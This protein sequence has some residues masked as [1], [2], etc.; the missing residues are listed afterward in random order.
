MQPTA[1]TS[2]HR[3]YF[4]DWVRILAFFV[5]IAYHVGMY[6]VSWGW[7][8]KSPH[9]GA[10]PEPFML[11]SSPWRLGL[12]FFVAG[13]ASH[14][15]LRKM[16][17]GTFVRRRSLRLLLPLLFGM[18]AIVPP[19]P[20]LEVVEKLGYADGFVAFMRLYLA[21]YGG[22]CQDGCLILPTWNHLWF[23]A[24]LWVY[25]LALAACVA[26]LGEVR[27]AALARRIGACLRGWKLIA[28]PALFLA[29]VRILLADHFP[30][31]HALVDD[32][33]NH[34]TYLPLFLLGALVARS[35][36]VWT[37]ME[38][39]RWVALG[40]A[41]AAWATIVAW[42]A[43]PHHEHSAQMMAFWR[44]VMRYVYTLCAWGAIVAACG[45]ARRHLDRDGPARRYLTDAVFP[46]YIAHQ[47][48][49]VVLAHSF[50]PLDLAPGVE[51]L[52][53]M[54]LTATGSFAL[55]EAVR[56]LCW[57]R[58]LFGLAPR[59]SAARPASASRPAPLMR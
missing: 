50:K 19:Q 37:G 38:A 44:P 56:R 26:L 17:P 12:L 32:W 33:F 24:Y 45:F 35:P 28:L 58:P 16:A 59:A 22:F 7:H 1:I 42:Y 14:F 2:N 30:S 5:L 15:L 6:Y 43:A 53:L 55:Y 47:T 51:A 40:I 52:M 21:G 49:I 3:L 39:Q 9:A 11:L 13:V 36:A 27:I 18:L 31:T 23:V 54:V 10:G 8:V 48:L 25:T 20:Y 46:V 4:L 29:L 57:A 34:A 41:L